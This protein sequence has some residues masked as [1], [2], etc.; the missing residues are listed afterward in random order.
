LRS[1]VP[2]GTGICHN[3]KQTIANLA[4]TDIDTYLISNSEL[5]FPDKRHVLSLQCCLGFASLFGEVYS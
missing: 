5:F 2:F 1:E 3:Y 4:C